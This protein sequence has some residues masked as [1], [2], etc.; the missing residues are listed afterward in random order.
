MNDLIEA[1]K[2][3]WQYAKNQ[4]DRWPTACE[5]DILYVNKIDIKKMN[6][7]TVRKLAKLGFMPGIDS[8]YRTI[9]Y[10]LGEDF[11]SEGNYEN[12]TDEQWDKIKNELYGAFWSYRYGSN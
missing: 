9:A 3:L 5:H 10:N 12:I 11:A 1:L 6:A 8:D 2:I 4:D 7:E